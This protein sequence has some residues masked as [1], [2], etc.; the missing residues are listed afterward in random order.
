MT[1]PGDRVAATEAS[2][3][4]PSGRRRAYV[5]AVVLVALL[6]LTAFLSFRWGASGDSADP[7]PTTS[8]EPSAPERLS[9]AEIYA[10]VAPSIVTIEGDNSV[11][12]GVI[13]NAEG[14]VLTAF[15]VVDDIGAIT[16]TFA[17]GTTSAAT[18]LGADPANDV[19]A[20]IPATLPTVVV[21]AVFGSSGR[22]AVGDE[23]VA[24]GNQLGL[25]GSTT[26]GVV[27][28]LDRIADSER[29][30]RI[31]GLIQFDAAV[32]PGS[33]GGPLVNARGETVAIV[34]SLANPTAAGTFIGVGF[35]VPIGTALAT[36]GGDGPGPP[37]PQQ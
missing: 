27:S 25:T 31:S 34:V 30:S 32:N 28:G 13:A 10:A 3:P 12:T 4:V 1:R 26:A 9:T 8:P 2:P 16:L 11:G 37:G 5:V 21:P 7:A 29:G 6:A 35:A 33:S 24:I 17:D 19:A 23:V 22:L 15:H 14:I 36:G 20:L 18:V